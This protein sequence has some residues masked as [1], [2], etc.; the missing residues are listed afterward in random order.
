M[1]IF[2]GQHFDVGTNNNISLN[3]MKKIVQEHLPQVVFDYVAERKGD[4]KYT[5]ANIQPLLDLE[6]GAPIYN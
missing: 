5:K 3:E 6:L 1:V 4:V 2:N